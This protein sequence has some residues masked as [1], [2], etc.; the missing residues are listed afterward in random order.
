MSSAQTELLR[1]AQAKEAKENVGH[2]LWHWNL[3]F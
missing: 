1:T 3:V 2:W